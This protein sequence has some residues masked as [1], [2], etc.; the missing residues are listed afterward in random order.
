MTIN[1]DH[2]LLHGITLEMIL[3]YFI[4]NYGYEWLAER[5]RVNCFSS[6]PSKQSSLKFLRKTEWA[7]LQLQ[8]LYIRT[9]RETG[10]S[11]EKIG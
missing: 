9:V 1:R 7:R 10:K 4:S 6:Q 3:D 11:A 5:I 2:A 8:G